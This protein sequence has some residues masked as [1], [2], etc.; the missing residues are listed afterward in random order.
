MLVCSALFDLNQPRLAGETA[1]ASAMGRNNAMKIIQDRVSGM[2]R[3]VCVLGASGVL[4]GGVVRAQEVILAAEATPPPDVAAEMLMQEPRIGLVKW[5]PFDMIPRINSSIYY[6]DGVRRLPKEDD[7]V[8]AIS[9]GIMAVA[10]DTAEGVGKVVSFDYSPAFLFYIQGTRGD[11]ITH[12]G[13]MRARL[14]F[15]KLELGLNQGITMIADPDVDVST[16]TR[17]NSYRTRLTSLYAVGEKTSAEIN[18]GLSIIDYQSDA[19]SGSWRA[20]NDNWFNYEY[21]PKLTGGVGVTLGYSEIERSPNQTFQ[22]VLLRAIYA[23]AERVTLTLSGGGEIRQ[24]R[25]D[26]VGDRVSPV[27]TAVGAFQPRDGTMVTLQANQQF[28]NSASLTGQDL[29]RVGGRVALRQRVYRRLSM[30]VSGTYYHSEYR[31]AATGVTASRVDDSFLTQIEFETQLGHR[32]RM[33]VFY[34]YQNNQSNLELY[35]YDRHRVGA[36][37]AWNY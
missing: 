16:R 24:Y 21:S 17:R 19:Y 30:N 25:G 12:A 7:V 36:R 34:D 6:S 14:L 29:M 11:E 37:V 15:P 33:G 28:Q 9:P 35:D 23:V 13:Q 1:A 5:G 3:V 27:W 22:Q 4:M 32:L 26:G 10:S 18:L 20:A 2:A 8:V 31:A